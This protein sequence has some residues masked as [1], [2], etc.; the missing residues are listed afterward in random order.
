[1]WRAL[2]A[3]RLEYRVHHRLEANGIDGPV[4]LDGGRISRFDLGS[5][6]FNYSSDRLFKTAGERGSTDDGRTS[7][8]RWYA[9]VMS[10][11]WFPTAASAP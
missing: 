11:R 10:P 5:L 4:E 8:I 1:M 2:C 6:T 9:D 7:A 3:R